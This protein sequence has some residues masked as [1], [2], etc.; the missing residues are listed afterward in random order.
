M[1]LKLSGKIKLI[2]KSSENIPTGST[3]LNFQKEYTY[4]YGDD[5]I[6]E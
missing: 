2:A 6:I 3:F 5:W 4:A 1:E